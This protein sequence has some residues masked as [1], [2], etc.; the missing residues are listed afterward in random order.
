MHKRK[1]TNPNFNTNGPMPDEIGPIPNGCTTITTTYINILTQ[2]QNRTVES[3]LS[4][5]KKI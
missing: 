2:T 3:N 1:K 5:C 4:L